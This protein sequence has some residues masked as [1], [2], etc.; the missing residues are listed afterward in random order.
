MTAKREDITASILRELYF[1][2]NFSTRQIGEILKCHPA[3]INKKLHGCGITIKNPNKKV[4]LNE[5]KLINLYIKEKLST[6]KIAAL[7]GCNVRTVANKMKAYKVKARSIK[8]G[9]ISKNR[10]IDLYQNKRLSLK[11][12]GVMYKMTSSGILKRVKKYRIPLRRSWETNTG[13]KL[14]FEGTFEEKAYMI[15]FRLGDLGVRQSS[16]RTKL[17]IVGSNTTKHEQVTL[18]KGLFNKFSKVWVSSPNLI[19]VMSVS[20]I[21][22]PSFSFLLP[23]NDQVEDWVR[24]NNN[25]MR[26]FVAGYIDAEGSF[27]I[28]NNR[29][30]FRLGSYDKNI[31]KEIY[32][33]LK[34]Q[35]IKSLFELERKKKLGQN[36]NFW[37]I[38]I[39]EAGSLLLFCK[40]FRQH[41][42]HKKRRE[43][44]KRAIENINLRQ[45]N[46]TIRL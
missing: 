7:V 23:K 28:Y 14:P 19:G 45:R 44:L 13:T 22:H 1:G 35:R 20:T 11:K 8:K 10:L 36:Q 32:K 6:Y 37:R 33:W 34:S 5:S 31:L 2:K 3:T 39:N 43:D 30:K 16:E 38:T 4:E 29:A 42:K 9:F 41:I 18:I 15:G 17:I 27:G 26:A 12:I 25:Y 21:L 46:G 24:L 40:T